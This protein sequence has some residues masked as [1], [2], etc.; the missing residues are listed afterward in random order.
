MHELKPTAVVMNMFYTGLGI[1]RSLGEHGVPVIGL[2]AHPGCYGNFTRYAKIVRCPD[3][4]SEPEALLEF[5]LRFGRELGQKSVLFPTRDDDVIFLDRY[6]TEL[7]RWFT[8][9]IP[10][11]SAALACLDK[12]ETFVAAT[13]AGVPTPRSWLISSIHELRAILPELTYPCVLKPVAAADWR[14]G[15]N[16]GVVGG[17]KAIPLNSDEELL[18]EYKTVAAAE[19]RALVQE[20]V[21]G[22][23]DCLMIAAC[24]MDRNSRLVAGFNTR[25]VLQIPE[26]FGTGCI[27]QA[28]DCRA[29]LD[30]AVQLLE[31]MKFSGIAEVEFKWDAAAKQYKLIEVNPRAWD[32]HRL[33][34]SC[35]T[36]LA[37][38]AYHEHAGLTLPEVQRRPSEQ[39]W[40]SED[41]FISSALRFLV[42]GDPQW[43]SM[44]RLARGN[45]IY[46]IWSLKDP[47]PAIA[48]SVT[49]F[50]PGL[51]RMG[52]RAGWSAVGRNASVLPKK[53]ANA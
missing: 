35:G 6:R 38:L 20:M 7:A 17:R 12:W 19:E 45:R 39:K 36:D 10:E 49:R 28:A 16:W 29:V 13:R 25:K 27:V 9:A 23:D 33:G 8:P 40:I 30:L 42:K 32:Q 41:V 51:L 24:Y 37:L 44:F 50:V 48:Y 14:K 53:A 47:L 15:V 52:L 22:D 1:A 46:A 26:K 21:P 11:A 2:S 5:L 3:S 34:K 18:A 4:R 43:R 31:S